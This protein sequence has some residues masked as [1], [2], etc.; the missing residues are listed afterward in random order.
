MAESAGTATELH[1]HI[2]GSVRP[3]TIEDL[4]RR[5]GIDLPGPAE[6]LA[7]VSPSCTSLVEY[8]AAIDVALDVLQTPEALYRAAF[9]LVEDW[10]ADGVHHGEARFAPALHRRRGLDLAAITEAVASGLRDGGDATGVET[11]L[12][13]CCLRPAAPDV[14]WAVVETAATSDQVIGLDVSGPEAGVSLLPHAAA[15]RAARDAGLRITVH[16]GEADGPRSVWD[17]ID[18]LGAERIGHGVRSVRDPALVRRLATDAIALEVCPTSN[19]QTAAVASLAEHPIDELRRAGVPVTVSCDGRTVS[20]VTLQGERAL[21]EHTFGWTSAD[22]AAAQANAER[23]AF[24][25][26]RSGTS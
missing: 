10:R 8:I 25:D 17:A 12:I 19:V 26:R 15:F 4:A 13:L 23:A 5:Q 21:L 24:T 2:D 11:R 20:G 14:T 22:W 9:E 3:S 18:E 16:A 1:C 7:R 6:A